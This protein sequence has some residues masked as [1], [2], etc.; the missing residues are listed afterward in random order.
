MYLKTNT[1]VMISVVFLNIAKSSDI[2]ATSIIALQL[3]LQCEL[4][5]SAGNVSK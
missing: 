5:V 4:H 2:F 3:W 1:L